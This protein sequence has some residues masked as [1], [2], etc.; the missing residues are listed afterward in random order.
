VDAPT[1]DRLV[2]HAEVYS[3]KAYRIRIRCHNLGRVP[4]HDS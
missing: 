3:F 2:Q 4:N 1:F